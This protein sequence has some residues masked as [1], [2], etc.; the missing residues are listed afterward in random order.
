MYITLD[1]FLVQEFFKFQFSGKYDK[2]II[3][4][5]FKFI[6]P[7]IIS[8]SQLDFLPQNIK[9]R[10]SKISVKDNVFIIRKFDNSLELINSSKLKLMLS[11]DKKD[12]PYFNIFQN[13][14]GNFSCTLF[15][16]EDREKAKNHIKALLKDSSKIYIYDNNFETIKV[17]LKKIIPRNRDIKIFCDKKTQKKKAELKD[18][19]PNIE[20]ANSKKEFH[21]RYITTN[22]IEIIL[23]SG[24]FYLENNSKD[25]TY[26]INFIS[27]S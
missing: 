22:K 8:E 14:S 5:L 10:I 23:S 27:N 16:N 19:F 9:A 15:K 7:F 1:D 4:H 12:F 2:N 11:S 25:F 20:F 3:F 17:V 21:D 26:I 18:L 6:K 24:L 13:R